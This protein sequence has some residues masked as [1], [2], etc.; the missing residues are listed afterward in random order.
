MNSR[1]SAA[2]DKG[3]NKMTFMAGDDRF[4][5]I[6]YSFYFIMSV[7]GLTHILNASFDRINVGISPML[8]YNLI[9]IFFKL[10]RT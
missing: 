6:S 10:S 5:E 4:A 8:L 7:A 1:G 2:A 3:C 9:I